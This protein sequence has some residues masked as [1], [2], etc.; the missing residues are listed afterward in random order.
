MASYADGHV[1]FVPNNIG[2]ATYFA[3]GTRNGGE[4]VAEVP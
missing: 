2:I 4:T 3:L 1:S